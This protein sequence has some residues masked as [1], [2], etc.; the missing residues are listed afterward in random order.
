[1][2]DEKAKSRTANNVYKQ[3]LVLAYLEIPAEFPM[4]STCLQLSVT[5][6]A[7]AHTRNVATHLK[8]IAIHITILLFLLLF[9]CKKTSTPNEYLNKYGI[10]KA[11]YQSDK[12]ILSDLT[13]SRRDSLRKSSATPEGKILEVYIDT[14]FYNPNDKIVFLSITKKENQ[15][16]MNDAG[17]S[18]S[19]ECYIGIKNAESKTI[20]ILDRLKYSS[21][22]DEIDGFNRVKKSNR[23]IYLTEMEFIDNRFNIN[24]NRFWTSKV[25]KKK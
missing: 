21:T 19:G 17:I 2:G 16:A 14:I 13:K 12:K 11:E 5:N 20:K 8:K 18:Y 3:W 9:S 6:H 23:N 1:M 10:E 4:A 22:S 15:Y 7:T 24:D 25:W